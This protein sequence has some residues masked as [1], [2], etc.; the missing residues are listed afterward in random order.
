MGLDQF[1]FQESLFSV[2]PNMKDAEVKLIPEC[3]LVGRVV[4]G[5]NE[6]L[7]NIF[8]QIMAEQILN[9]RKQWM[10]R[11]GANT[12][13]NGQYRMENLP[14]GRYV[15]RT[16][17]RA[18]FVN[19]PAMLQMAAERGESVPSNV[20]LNLGY[21]P[22]YFPNASDR[23]SAQ[24]LDVKPGEEA[25]ADFTIRAQH[26]FHAGGT[27]TGMGGGSVMVS[28]E[29]PDRQSIPL[30]SRVNPQTGAFH[31]PLVFPGTWT[32]VFRTQSG[33]P[34]GAI[35]RQSVSITSADVMNL[36]VQL[37]PLASIPVQ[38][39]EPTTIAPPTADPGQN[40]VTQPKMAPVQVQLLSD[41]GPAWAPMY[42]AGSPGGDAG[43]VI[44]NV[45][46][47][48]YRARVQSNGRAECLDTI[49]AGSTDLSKSE[50]AVAEGT[51]P[52]PIHVTLRSDCANLKGTV[53]SGSSNL[54]GMVLLL[55]KNLAE[56]YRVFP[57]GPDGTFSLMGLS[58]G[59]YQLFALS[60][61]AG[62]EYENPEAM[63]GL[64]GQ[65]V[66]LDPNQ[67]AVVSTELIVRGDSQ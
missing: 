57:I 27:V 16:N 59:D 12:N 7:S 13:A 28:V 58:P 26:G 45:P 30:G 61:L 55:P 11:G 42:M 3:Q 35:A 47:G 64:S 38:I 19:I 46:P 32:L 49:T 22:T 21:P 41:E 34:S 39:D 51:T 50:Y 2:G 56:N 63:R 65:D 40:S 5:D 33:G 62:L 10:Q 6:P 24:P 36:Q 23:A 18:M 8:V 53:R 44:P 25:Q 52:V 20:D 1:F 14:P 15:V 66:H 43:T 29:G 48:S 54:K 60:S 4:N 67:S 31:L 9:G 17:S 37:R